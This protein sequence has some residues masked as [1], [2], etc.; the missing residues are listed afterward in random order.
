MTKL[1]E[2]VNSYLDHKEKVFTLLST[3]RGINADDPK[4]QEIFPGIEAISQTIMRA[5]SS[6]LNYGQRYFAGRAW[7][8][9]ETAVQETW[10]QMIEKAVSL[11]GYALAA[12]ILCSRHAEETRGM[13]YNAVK[14]FLNRQSVV[15]ESTALA[16][17]IGHDT[18]LLERL[19]A[20]VQN[21]LDHWLILT[22]FK[23]RTGRET[24]H[25]WDAW[26]A[27]LSTTTKV[28]YVIGFTITKE[29]EERLAFEQIISSILPDNQ[30][31]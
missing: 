22:K 3:L 26:R 25:I 16:D 13:N 30:G 15:D 8:D 12:G 29:G 20:E 27:T 5:I 4:A 19:S 10:T 14:E 6:S 7:A 23:S 11:C 31:A 17:D 18:E 28:L 24:A 9:G 21:V 2:D 1:L